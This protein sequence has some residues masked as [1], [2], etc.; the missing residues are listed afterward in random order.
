MENV[1]AMN[2]LLL[3]ISITGL[4]AALPLFADEKKEVLLRFSQ[5]DNIIRVVLESEDSLI[6][7]TNIIAMLSG[8][9]IEFPALVTLKKQKD[10]IFE[11]SAKDR[12]LS[13]T[14]K[15]VE[16]L[17]SYKLT[18]PPRIV[19]DLKLAQKAVKEQGVPAE[20][21]SVPVEKKDEPKQEQP[22]AKPVARVIFLDA[23][24]GGY[25]YGLISKDTK[26]KDLNLILTKDLNAALSKKGDR[27]FLTRKVDQSLSIFE[28]IILINSKKPDIFISF[29]SSA[30]NAFVVYTATADE[31]A[32][33]SAARLF[34]L[35]AQQS[36]HTEKSGALAK[37]LGQS[38]K[39]EFKVDVFTREMPLPI[40][41]SMDSSAVLIEY[42]SLQLNTYDQ[43]MR[44][45]LVNAVLK[46][47]SP[48][49]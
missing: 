45:R 27:V 39:N 4:L 6:K 21:Q 48:H 22:V 8:I 7:N 41:Q 9:K 28:R 33:E 43:K 36:R 17:K 19:I 3:I 32:T 23:G 47:I 10:F 38:L 16:D 30:S 11:T 12:F 24:H 5:Q 42:P 20:K 13:I 29:H 35:S 25:D 44:D 18:S 49:E 26:E 46:G 34:S 31:P 14:L 15:N 40:L 2:K 37:A 1:S